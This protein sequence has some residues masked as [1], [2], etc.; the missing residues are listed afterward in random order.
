VIIRTFSDPVLRRVAS[1]IRRLGADA[2]RLAARMV[3]T[4]RAHRGVGLAAPQVGVSRRLIIVDTGDGLRVLVNPKLTRAAGAVVDWEGCLSFPGLLAEVERAQTV[5]V[6]GLGLDG[7]P[8]WIEAE[9]F[10]ARILQHELDHLD[11]V[12]IL[13]RARSVECAEPSATSEAELSGLGVPT[14]PGPTGAE[15][16]DAVDAGD[17]GD[18]GTAHPLRVAFLGTPG[19]ACPTL[20]SLVAAGHAVVGVVT[21]PDRPV[22]RGGHHIRA[23]AVKQTAQAFGLPVWQGDASEAKTS[24]AKV[25]AG[26]RAEVAVV[27]AYGVILPERVLAAPGLGCLNLHASLLPDY[28]G[29]APIQRAILDGRS[30][31][32]VTVIRMDAGVDTGDILAQREV[33]IGPD[34]TSGTLHDKLAGV[35]AELVLHTLELLGAG[36]VAPRPQ[37]SGPSAPAPRLGPE[38]EILDWRRTAAELERQVRALLPGPGAYTLLGGRRVKVLR[39]EII[40]AP[41]TGATT[42][43]LDQPAKPGAPGTVVGFDDGSPVVLTGKGRLALRL[44][45]PAGGTRLAGP[46]FVNGYRLAAGDR[47][48]DRPSDLQG[49]A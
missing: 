18:P 43:K 9:D 28:R 16:A 37:P 5:G 20:E 11:G 8:A 25:L 4:M 42:G 48:D 12:V 1:P 29:A 22:G 2:S 10:L 6:E 30:V 17:V 23:S 32:G 47:F 26:W 41:G 14:G 15:R 19:F 45:Q 31:T 36:R 46:D 39:A 38:D 21:Q 49:G 44:V 24:L 13:D 3:K 40:R 7:R 35:G 34:D 27:V 33:P